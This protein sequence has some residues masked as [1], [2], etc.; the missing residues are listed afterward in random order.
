MVSDIVERL[1]EYLYGH[2]REKAIEWAKED[3][4]DSCYLQAADIIELLGV[5]SLRQQLADH[6]ALCVKCM[7]EVTRERNECQAREMT[8]MDA[9]AVWDSL[10]AYQYT[11][12]RP[13]M[14]A[15][16]K[17]FDKGA[18]A[19]AMP[20]DSTVLDEA[21]KQAK[22]EGGG[23]R[24]LMRLRSLRTDHGMMFAYDFAAWQRN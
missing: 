10:M 14:T 24:C 22:L 2:S 12:T 9:L 1:A 16:Q 11:G 13:A 15:L 7:A 17:A 19:L 18:A 6:D 3:K 5:E 21:L 8:Q 20:S 4:F 23:R